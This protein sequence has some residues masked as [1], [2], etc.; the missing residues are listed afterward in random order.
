MKPNIMFFSFLITAFLFSNLG[1]VSTVEARSFKDVQCG[2]NV[3]KLEFK[4]N[5]EVVKKHR[6]NLALCKQQTLEYEA[7]DRGSKTPRST[8]MSTTK[9]DR[10]RCKFA[11]QEIYDRTNRNCNSE[12]ESVD[13]ILGGVCVEAYTRTYHESI[14]RWMWHKPYEK[15]DIDEVENCAKPNEVLSDICRVA[16]DVLLSSMQSMPSQ[17]HTRNPH[18]QCTTFAKRQGVCSPSQRDWLLNAEEDDVS[19]SYRRWYKTMD[20]AQLNNA[21]RNVLGCWEKLGQ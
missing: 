17:I 9:I 15:E 8:T 18:I 6:D 14:G 21:W 3:V 13:E 7:V 11:M 12:L 16:I 1:S 2:T 20:I 5:G 19:H 4:N 10:G